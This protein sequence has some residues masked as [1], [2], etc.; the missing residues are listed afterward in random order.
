M[1]KIKY[2]VFI[3][4]RNYKICI[5]EDMLFWEENVLDI[6]VKFFL[7]MWKWVTLFKNIFKFNCFFF[8][9]KV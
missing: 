5:G 6:Y 4:N 7:Y 3:R 1:L 2:D 9:F 8:N